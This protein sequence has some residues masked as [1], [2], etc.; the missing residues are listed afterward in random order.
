VEASTDPQEP[1]ER[2]TQEQAPTK[3]EDP[4]QG[5]EEQKEEASV[6]SPKIVEITPPTQSPKYQ[7]P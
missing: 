6:V 7:E 2:P 3:A 1:V 5:N 4:T